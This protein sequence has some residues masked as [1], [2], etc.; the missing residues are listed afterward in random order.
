MTFFHA[1]QCFKLKEKMFLPST[2]ANMQEF[3]KTPKL[4]G[5][6]NASGLRKPQPGSSV[7]TESVFSH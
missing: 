2:Q 5:S 1:K 6:K 7:L 4:G 3:Y